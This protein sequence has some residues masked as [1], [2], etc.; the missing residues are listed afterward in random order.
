MSKVIVIIITCLVI[1]GC[2]KSDE[3]RSRIPDIQYVIELGAVSTERFLEIVENYAVTEALKVSGPYD[4]PS[5]IGKDYAITVFDHDQF[6]LVAVTSEGLGYLELHC[7]YTLPLNEAQ[8]QLA[9]HSEKI[10]MS[11]IK[12]L[13]GAKIKHMKLEGQVWHEKIY[14][15]EPDFKK[16]STC[17]NLNKT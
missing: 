6:L 14:H 7:S 15:G 17:E 1:F 2:D 16:I 4:R 13:N 3:K 5:Q 11:Y 8:S 10:F 12:N 9:F